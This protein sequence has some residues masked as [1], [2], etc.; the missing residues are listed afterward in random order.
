[1]LNLPVAVFFAMATPVIAAEC[2]AKPRL[3]WH[4]DVFSGFYS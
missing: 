3:V 1:M 4:S 2:A